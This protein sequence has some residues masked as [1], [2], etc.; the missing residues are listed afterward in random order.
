MRFFTY[1]LTT[2]TI[3]INFAD[4]VTFLSIQCSTGASCNVLGNLQ[5][6]TLS[7]TAVTLTENQGI[8]LTGSVISPLDG[9]T[10]THTGGNVDIVIGL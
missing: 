9:I 6:K 1:V 3:S 8:N 2:G 10:I 4:N 7:P 5:F